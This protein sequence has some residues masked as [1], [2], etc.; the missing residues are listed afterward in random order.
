MVKKRL[1]VRP[2][3]FFVVAV[4][5]ALVVFVRCGYVGHR[6]LLIDMRPE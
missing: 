4:V 5:E 1:K 6:K 3:A 2:G